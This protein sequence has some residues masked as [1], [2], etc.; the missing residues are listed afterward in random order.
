MDLVTLFP[1]CNRKT[2]CAGLSTRP[3]RTYRSF[4][5]VSDISYFS[6]YLPTSGGQEDLVSMAPWAGLKLIRIQKNIN[7]ILAIELI[8]AGAANSF[9]S[10]NL[11]SGHGTSKVLDI[12]KKFC[13]FSKGDRSLTSEIKSVYNILSSGQLYRDISQHLTLE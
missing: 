11:K 3:R 2:F 4:S 12:L 13:A 6:P 1:S 5:G 7:R 10:S 8:V 9:I